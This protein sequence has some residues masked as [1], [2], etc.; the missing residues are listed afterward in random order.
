VPCGP[1]NDLAEVFADPQ[2]RSRDMTVE[3]AHPLAGSISVVASPLKLSA[4]PVTYRKAPP[5][6]GADT[7]QV[8][9]EFGFDAGAV[10]ALRRDGAL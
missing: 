7:E 2:V 4:T 3:M 8:L 10:A 1:I 5:L 6:L 9:A